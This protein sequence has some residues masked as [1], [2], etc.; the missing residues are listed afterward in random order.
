MSSLNLKLLIDENVRIE[1]YR[2]LQKQGIDVKLTSKGLTNGKIA[3]FSLTE[4]RVLV[5][6]DKDF[7]E[8]LTKDVFGVIWLRIP[9]NDSETLISAFSK[10][11]KSEP[12]SLR[13][14][15]VILSKEK[16]EIVS[17]WEEKRME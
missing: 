5:T 17:L 14:K 15:L 8:S 12:L 2:F 1:L 4:K 3:E 13:G 9:Q 7:T 11:L 10:I 6:N 16:F